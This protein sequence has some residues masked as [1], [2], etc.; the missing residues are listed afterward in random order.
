MIA[1]L[2]LAA[3][4]IMEN[5]KGQEFGVI[6]SLLLV[7]MTIWKKADQLPE[8]IKLQVWQH[9]SFEVLPDNVISA[10]REAGC[11]VTIYITLSQ[12]ETAKNLLIN[13]FSSMAKDLAMIT[14]VNSRESS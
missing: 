9:R 8:S 5:I 13:F 2:I 12:S 3:F 14:L 7:M 6:I 4:I 11:K 1:K 10:D